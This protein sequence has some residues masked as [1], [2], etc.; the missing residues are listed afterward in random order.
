MFARQATVAVRLGGG[1]CKAAG[2]GWSPRGRVA[3]LSIVLLDLTWL[4]S[5]QING[6]LS[7]RSLSWFCPS[8]SVCVGPTIRRVSTIWVKHYHWVLHDS[9]SIRRLG[10]KINFRRA[11]PLLD[12]SLIRHSQTQ[13]TN[14]AVIITAAADKY[15]P[16][17]LAAAAVP[18]GG[19]ICW[20][21]RLGLLLWADPSS[22]MG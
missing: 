6:V 18:P 5:S 4:P 15:I 2:P 10:F 9:S 22:G 16:S 3:P 21:V 1:N 11:V 8:P 20:W 7:P 13:R 19:G 17:T 14:Y 12:Y